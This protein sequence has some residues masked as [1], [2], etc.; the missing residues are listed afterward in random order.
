MIPLGVLGAAHVTAAG[1]SY[2]DEVMA[3]SP[4]FYYPLGDAGN[5]AVDATA[6]STSSS[7]SWPTFGGAALGDAATSADFATSRVDVNAAAIVDA[8]S[9][10]ITVEALIRADTLS[11][12][13]N[14]C[15]R[16][17]GGADREYQFRLSGGKIS[18]AQIGGG[19][20]VGATTLSTGTI[21]HVAMTRVLGGAAILYLNGSSDVTGTQSGNFGNGSTARYNIGYSELSGGRDFF[22]GLIGGVAVYPSALSAARILAHA[23]AAGVA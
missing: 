8:V 16:D 20:I 21:Y 15:S 17:L 9:G 1:G 23:Q 10:E 4:E 18:L 11:G 2:Y 13:D 12:D 6:N 19:N 3:D 7:S 14:I 5:P 22:D